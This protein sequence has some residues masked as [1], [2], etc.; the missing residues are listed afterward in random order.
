MGALPTLACARDFSNVLPLHTPLAAEAAAVG[1]HAHHQF[2]A[3]VLDAAAVTAVVVASDPALGTFCG[4]AGS[5]DPLAWRAQLPAAM[6]ALH[7]SGWRAHRRSSDGTG[8]LP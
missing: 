8:M 3:A 1:P 5:A 7:S 4:S 6:T 2:V